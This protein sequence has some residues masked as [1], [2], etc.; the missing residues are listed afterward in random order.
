MTNP[1]GKEVESTQSEE[2]SKEYRFFVLLLIVFDSTVDLNLQIQ[3][4]DSERM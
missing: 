1:L 3:N 2:S 4:T